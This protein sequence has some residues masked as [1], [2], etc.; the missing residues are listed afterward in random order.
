M[1]LLA[2]SFPPTRNSYS[3][4]RDASFPIGVPHSIQALDEGLEI[5]LIFTDGNFDASGTTFMLSDWLAHTPLEIVAQN[6][7]VDVSLLGGIPQK[8]PYVFPSTKEPPPLGHSGDQAVPD[9]NGEVP[10]PFVFHLADQKKTNAPGGWVKIQDSVTNFP[11]SVDVASALVFVEPNGLR[12]LHW[13][14]QDGGWK[15]ASIYGRHRD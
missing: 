3:R 13:H 12:E 10:S 9:P 5:L 2:A 4:S 11:V 1:S 6:F 14:N 7:G 8:D 15:C